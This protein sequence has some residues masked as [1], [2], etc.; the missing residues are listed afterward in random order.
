ML[1]PSALFKQEMAAT[2][3]I[4]QQLGHMYISVNYE[5]K[6]G[7]GNVWKQQDS[8]DKS[9]AAAVAQE[10]VTAG[11]ELMV[12]TSITDGKQSRKI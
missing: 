7:I 2:K 8:G 11:A 3:L 5:H 6:H 1:S 10:I 12:C 9:K 4:K